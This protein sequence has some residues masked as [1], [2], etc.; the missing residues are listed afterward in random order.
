MSEWEYSTFKE[1]Q[2]KRFNIRFSEKS[3]TLLKDLL[4]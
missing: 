4:K 3:Q 2:V 1:K